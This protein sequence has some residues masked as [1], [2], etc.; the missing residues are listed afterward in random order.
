MTRQELVNM[1]K[2]KVDELSPL[3]GE[4][5]AF[6]LQNDKPVDSLADGLLDEC[7]QE[8]L[9]KAPS[10]KVEGTEEGG[11][12]AQGNKDGS[13]YVVLPEG[14][15]RLLEFRMSEW[16]R[17]VTVAAEAGSETALMQGNRY[18]RG[19]LCKPVCVYGKRGGA[20]V[21]E[22][23]TVKKSHVIDRFVYVK[24]CAAE[25]VPVELQDVLTWWCAS[26]VLQIFGNV[27]G[28]QLA[29]ERGK[30]LL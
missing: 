18:L 9:M 29:Y 5:V 3:D 2:T 6:G 16:E 14:F 13:G 23:Y 28:A 27:N 25:N 15:L 26:R 1:V 30:S 24:E 4:I 8:V 20:N 21:L 17:P 19:G 10:L 22:Y 11:V 7:A 12:S